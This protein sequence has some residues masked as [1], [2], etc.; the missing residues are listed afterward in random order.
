M[1]QDEETSINIENN[2]KIHISQYQLT[3]NYVNSI[4]KA[5]IHEHDNPKEI[6]LVFSS[7]AFN[8][9]IG[10]G[11]GMY[12]KKME[13]YKH[14][15]VHRVSGSSIG[16]LL[17]L[18]YIM[19][20]INDE[21]TFHFFEKYFINAI[22]NFKKYK[23]LSIYRTFI[24]TYVYKTFDTDDMSKINKRLYIT[25]SDTKKFKK[26]TVC[27]YKNR[28]NLIDCL[29]RSSHIPYLTNGKS[30]YKER[31]IDGIYPYIFYNKKKKNRETLFVNM[32]CKTYLSGCLIIKECDIYKRILIGIND[33]NNFF[34]TGNSPLCIY[35]KNITYKNQ[36]ERNLFEYVF[37]ILLFIMD[38]IVSIHLNTQMLFSESII[39][40]AVYDFFYSFFEG[41]I[42]GFFFG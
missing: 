38:V 14:I 31:Y 10:M 13:E 36:I 16:A 22:N 6:D 29:L 20:D 42:D 39:Y 21:N 33:A 8:A 37:F 32:M 34:T 12:L 18:W 7:G 35:T 30:K 40:N 5:Y 23:N 2:K 25:Y 24:E 28:K 26:I 17:S 1:S 4:T 11:L 9:P 15:K 19:T 41:F 27:N 3:N